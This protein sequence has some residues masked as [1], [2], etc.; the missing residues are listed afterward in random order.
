M[1]EG[2]LKVMMLR[3]QLLLLRMRRLMLKSALLVL[4]EDLTPRARQKLR[5]VFPSTLNTV[6]GARIVL[7]DVELPLNTE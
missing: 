2:V 3:K 6:L 5:R 1:R 4:L 7:V